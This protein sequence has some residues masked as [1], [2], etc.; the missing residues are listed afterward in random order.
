MTELRGRRSRARHNAATQALCQ[1]FC[2][3]GPLGNL[4]RHRRPKVRNRTN[5]G[6]M[7]TLVRQVG[8]SVNAHIELSALPPRTPP[9]WFSAFHMATG[10]ECGGLHSLR[11]FG[12]NG[13][14]HGCHHCVATMRVPR[15]WKFD[16][17][18]GL[19]TADLGALFQTTS[20]T[21]CGLLQDGP[22]VVPQQKP[23]GVCLGSQLRCGPAGSVGRLLKM[24]VFQK[25][26]QSRTS[27]HNRRPTTLTGTATM[28]GRNRIS[29]SASGNPTNN[30]ANEAPNT[31]KD[32]LILSLPGINAKTQGSA[33][34]HV[35]PD[36]L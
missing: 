5:L 7:E 10:L 11:R 35:P 28:S 31:T 13:W 36:R 34:P 22:E 1:L 30:I 19:A 26:R 21:D 4:L 20:P 25:K 33:S 12:G 2:E 14:Q 3:G 16:Q 27:P 17:I 23:C 29:L 9:S 8:A 18:R 15:H 24:H 32:A 6:A